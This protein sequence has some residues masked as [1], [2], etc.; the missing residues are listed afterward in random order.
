VVRLRLDELSTPTHEYYCV[1]HPHFC[2][3]SSLAN[4]ALSV[5][6][7]GRAGA[8]PYRPPKNKKLRSRAE[9]RTKKRWNVRLGI[10][11]KLQLA[12]FGG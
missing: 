9:F 10:E 1:S 8:R 6:R 7:P 5:V 4:T 12:A 11:T 2:Q 3:D